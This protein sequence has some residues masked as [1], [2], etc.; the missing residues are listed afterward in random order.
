[1]PVRRNRDVWLPVVDSWM[2]ARYH[3]YCG[4]LWVQYWR[5]TT[6]RFMPGAPCV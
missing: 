1:M 2:A 5:R 6:R 4:W 3:R